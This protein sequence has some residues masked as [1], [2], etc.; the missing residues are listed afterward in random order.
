MFNSTSTDEIG[1]GQPVS[2]MSCPDLADI[3]LSMFTEI[4]FYEG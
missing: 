3:A 2:F 1:D 4:E